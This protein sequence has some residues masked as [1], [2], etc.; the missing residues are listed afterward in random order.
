MN[1]YIKKRNVYPETDIFGGYGRTQ[2]ET[3]DAVW[4]RASRRPFLRRFAVDMSRQ[5]NNHLKEECINS[6]SLLL[7]DYYNSSCNAN[8]AHQPTAFA[9]FAV[10]TDEQSSINHQSF[11]NSS[12]DAHRTV[13]RASSWTPTTRRRL[14][15]QPRTRSTS[16]MRTR[17]DPSRYKNRGR[18]IRITSRGARRL[19][20]SRMGARR[21]D[22]MRA[23]HRLTPTRTRV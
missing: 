7:Y 22:A 8:E 3:P 5:K 12:S 14:E 13:S 15:T 4:R 9:I 11:F 1:E 21:D 17:S 2:N 6:D 10:G 20:E 23:T 18:A 19:T 16:S